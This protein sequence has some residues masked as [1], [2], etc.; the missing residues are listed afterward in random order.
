MRRSLI[1]DVCV[2]VAFHSVLLLSLYLL[3]AGHNQPGGGFVGGLVAAAAFALRYVAGGIAEVRAISRLR[4][5][6][7]LGLGL[8]AAVGTGAVALVTGGQF[9]ESAKFTEDLPLL[10]EVKATSALPFD[11]GVYLVVVGLVL[12]VMEALGDEALDPE[13]ATGADGSGPTAETPA[14]ET[15]APQGDVA[16]PGDQ[17]R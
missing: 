13:A 11:T 1:L 9:L 7:L 17:R 12:M 15:P 14:A 16:L 5:W 3:F 2:Q 4:P 6:T 10:G 8:L